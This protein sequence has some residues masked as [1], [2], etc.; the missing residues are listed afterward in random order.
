[1]VECGC[2]SVCVCVLFGDGEIHKHHEN[3]VRPPG[4]VSTATATKSP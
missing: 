2:G 4:A 1:M 3:V